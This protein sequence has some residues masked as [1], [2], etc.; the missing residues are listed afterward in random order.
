MDGQAGETG[1]NH[2]DVVGR[3]RL[4]ANAGCDSKRAAEA[5]APLVCLR[6]NG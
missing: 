4:N 2:D 6:V 3:V 5:L 1:G